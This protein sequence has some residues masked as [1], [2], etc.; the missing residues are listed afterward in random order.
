MDENDIYINIG[1]ILT[2]IRELEDATIGIKDGVIQELCSGSDVPA[3]KPVLHYENSIAVPG[4]VD[5]HIHGYRGH[6]V[7]SGNPDDVIAIAERLPEHG[8]TTFFPTTVSETPETLREVAN[9][10]SEI[11]TREYN[12]AEIAG[13]HLE[14]PYL[15]NENRGA[16]NAS[17]LRDPDIEEFD[18][19]LDASDGNVERITLAPERPGAIDLIKHARDRDVSVSIGHTGADFETANCAFD[20]GA[21]MVTHLYNGMKRFHHRRPGVLGAS[22]LRDDIY[23]ELI[24]DL[25]HL[26]PGGIEL[27]IKAKGVENTMLITDAISATGLSNGTYDLGG[28]EIVISDGVS[29]MRETDNLAGSTLTMAEA[30]RNVI[31]EISVTPS[32]AIRMA[33]L[34]PSTALSLSRHGRIAEGYVGNVTILD[35]MY[36]VQAT[37]VRGTTVYE[38]DSSERSR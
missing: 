19:L 3:D 30:V 5:A 16:Q 18:A 12:G 23:A 33:T 24:A 1:R 32:E 8:V 35:S 22:L 25:V 31:T 11:E 4:Y 27:A 37:I 9:A 14:G 28:R 7:S 15:D 6:D 26:H 36:E 13:L 20:M 17:A 29:R 10:I 2:P 34:N 38:R 21:S